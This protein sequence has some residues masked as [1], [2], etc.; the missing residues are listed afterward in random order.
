MMQQAI[1]ARLAESGITNPAALDV[2]K[3]LTGG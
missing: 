3:R 1:N 2:I